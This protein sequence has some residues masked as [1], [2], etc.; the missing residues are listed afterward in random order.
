MIGNN[1]Y[2][3]ILF[4]NFSS[5]ILYILKDAQM[6]I[7]KIVTPTFDALFDLR[8]SKQSEKYRVYTLL[9]NLYRVIKENVFGVY[10]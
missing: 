2:Y 8:G 7:F 9:L 6:L 1:N 5:D 3:K 4:I 10:P